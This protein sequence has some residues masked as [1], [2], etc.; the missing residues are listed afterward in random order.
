MAPHPN[1]EQLG[2]PSLEVGG[3]QLWVH[4]RQIPDSQDYDDGN[5]LRITAHCGHAGASVWA[6]GSILQVMDIV[7]WAGQ[8]EELANGS[9]Q[10]ASLGPLEPKLRVDLEKTDSLGQLQMT[11]QIT[12]SHMEQEHVF[13]FEID[14]SYLQG[15]VTQCRAIEKGYP[16]RGESARRGV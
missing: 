15:I 7:H 10:S 8:C 3:F 9:A 16:I 1:P 13:R 2:P 5:W 6:T 14:Q 4:G 12:P 11:V